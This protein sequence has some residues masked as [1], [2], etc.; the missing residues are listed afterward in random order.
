M[1]GK[2]PRAGGGALVEAA[3][4]EYRVSDPFFGS[5]A[6]CDADLRFVRRVSLVAVPMVLLI[7]ALTLW[8]A[9]VAG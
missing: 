6:D 8:L 5:A 3:P 4:A 9:Q 1:R 2:A 7:C